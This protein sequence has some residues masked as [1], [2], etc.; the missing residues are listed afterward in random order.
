[1]GK[2]NLTRPP[3]FGP[4]RFWRLFWLQRIYYCYFKSEC[5]CPASLAAAA[6]TA[7]TIHQ[8]PILY[9]NGCI[10]DSENAASDGL[11]EFRVV[12]HYFNLGIGWNRN[13]GSTFYHCLLDT[14]VS[15]ICFF[16]LI[17]PV[18]DHGYKWTHVHLPV[19]GWNILSQK[20]HPR[21]NPCWKSGLLKVSIV[22]SCTL[23]CWNDAQ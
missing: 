22:Y 23:R 1:M 7:P 6:A 11:F 18:N 20:P 17:Y 21:S 13:H 5:T 15:I 16:Y 12:N 3:C 8:I 9:T 10:Q 19:S 14:D 2:P 4:V